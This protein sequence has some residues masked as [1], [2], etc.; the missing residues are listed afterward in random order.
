M[1][2]STYIVRCNEIMSPRRKRDHGSMTEKNNISASLEDYLKTIHLIIGEKQAARA[3]DIATRM[4][5]GSSSVTGALHSLADKGLINYAPYDVITLTEE[6]QKAACDVIRR[7]EALHNFLVKVLSVGEDT[8]RQA[9]CEMEHALPPIILDRLIR[10]VD[11]IESCPRRRMAWHEEEGYICENAG[12]DIE[13]CQQCI[14]LC[15]ESISKQDKV[16]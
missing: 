4:G 3:K 2:G 15:V 11:Y 1:F 9:A 7:Q 10:F 16:V 5:V 6:G 8:A 13:K 14:S 12:A